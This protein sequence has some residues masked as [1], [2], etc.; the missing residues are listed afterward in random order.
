MSRFFGVKTVDLVAT[1]W[2]DK[3]LVHFLSSQSNPVGNETVNRKQ[4][5]GTVIPVRSAPVVKSYNKNI[6][7]VDLHDQ[8][9]GYYAV[10]KK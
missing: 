7:G 3:R 6:G 5:D 10:G 8:M 1:V 9:R 4:R 2:K